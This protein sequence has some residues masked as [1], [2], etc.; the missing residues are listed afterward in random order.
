MYRMECDE[1]PPAHDVVR[2]G[3]HASIP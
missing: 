3:F 1:C 2:T